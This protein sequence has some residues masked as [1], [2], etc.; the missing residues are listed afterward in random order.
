MVLYSEEDMLMLSGIQHFMFCPRQWALIHIE[1]QWSDNSLTT[2]GNLLHENVDNPYYRQ[3]NGSQITLRSLHIASKRLGLYGIAD[4]V[5][6]VTTDDEA[7]SIT[8]PRYKGFWK[9]IPVEY[10]RGHSKVNQC[11]RVQIAAQAMAIEEMYSLTIDYGVL[12][13][14]ETRRR[15]IVL[16]SEELRG[17]T[18]QK[19]NEMHH[20]FSSGEIPKSDKKTQCNR[21]SLY[22]I[23][24]PHISR[25]VTNYLKQELYEE[26]T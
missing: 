7:N 2:Q 16:I 22:D 4:A 6:L 10:K 23:C 26:I 11:D 20:I 17:L 21:C 13:Y 24:L 9:P 3:K 12:F 19:A 5:E 8:H 15:E 18:Q 1:Q 25:S 14:G